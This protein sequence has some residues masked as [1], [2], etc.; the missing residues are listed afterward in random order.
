MSIRFPR[1]RANPPPPRPSERSPSSCR[2]PSSP[3]SRSSP[4]TAGLGSP[5]IPDGDVAV[6]DEV[7]DGTVS[8]EDFDRGIDQAAAQLGLEEV[9]ARRRSAVPAD[10]R[11]G[12][13]G[14]APRDLGRGRGRRSR[15]HGHRRRDRRRAR[16]DQGA[17]LRQPR[18]V[19]ALQEGVEVHRRGHRPS[20]RADPAARPARGGDRPGAARD[21]RRRG[22][23]LLRDQHRELQPARQ[24]RRARD[25][26]LL[27]GEGRAGEGGA[28]GRRLRRRLGGRAKKYSQDQASKD[29]GGLLEGLVEGQGDPALEGQ[30]FDAAE[31]EL[32]G[33]FETDRGFYLL[34]VQ[35]ATEASTQPLDEASKAHPASSSRSARQQRIAS[36]FQADFV[37]KWTARTFCEPEVA[38]QLCE[39]RGPGARA[40]ERRLSP[41]QPDAAARRLHRSRIEP[42]TAAPEPRRQAPAAGGRRRR[43]ARAALLR[44]RAAPRGNRP[45][46]ARPGPRRP[47]GRRAADR[48]RATDRRRAARRGRRPPAPRRR[49]DRAARRAAD[50]PS[51]GAEARSPA[52]TRSRAACVASAP[53]IAPRTSARSS[54]TRSRR[55]TSSPTPPRAGDDAKL[56]DELGDVLFQVHF[57]SLLL[58][59]RGAGDLAAV[60]EGTTEKLIRRHP[61]VFGEATAEDSGE[62]LANWDRIKREQEGRARA[63]VRG[64]SREPAGASCTRASCSAGPPAAGG[65]RARRRR[66]RRDPGE[67]S[68]AAPRRARGWRRP[69]ASG[70]R[71]RRGRG[72]GRR[73]AL[74][75]AWI[76]PAPRAA[77]RSWRCGPRRSV[78]RTDAVSGS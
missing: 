65:R 48:G 16:D 3:P 59:E 55:P 46:P 4:R 1:R 21:H 78:F 22:R 32:V 61:H 15:H 71:A 9:A 76:S 11:P 34:Q 17:E 58:E 36:D 25:P 47:T 68:G 67:A 49:P 30:A 35:E 40:G 50:G 70:R 75:R 5:T 33:P 29:R 38:I 72:G 52:S 37:D 42:G 53:G 31:G 20:G 7:D 64:R 2:S 74:R 24:P 69:A 27:R 26:Q 41:E 54:R 19:R 10:P 6:V 43:H 57:L 14:A 62:V 77:T 63:P 44:R 73:A 23:G 39:L 45:D 66:G 56:L 13:A 8:Q 18:G 51:R 12:D 60:A 28:R